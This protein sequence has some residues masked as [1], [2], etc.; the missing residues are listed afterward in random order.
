MAVRRVPASMPPPPGRSRY[1]G[2][3]MPLAE[4]LA[5]PEEKPALEYWNGRVVQKAVPRRKHARIQRWLGELLGPYMRAHGGDAETEL[6]VWFGTARIPG[7]LVP[8]AV[9]YAPGKP[10]GDDDRSLPPTLAIE[11]RSKD[12]TMAAQRQKCRDMRENGVDVCWLIDPETRT[13]EVFD[14]SADG[15]P[16]PAGSKL[17]SPYLPGFSLALDELFSVLD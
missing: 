17:E 16:V 15:E 12:E 8:D 11:I 5:L 4:Y 6:R 14:G 10:Q 3:R 1:D 13:A 2:K 7:F 9:Y